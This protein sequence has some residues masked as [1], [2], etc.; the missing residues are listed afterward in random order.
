VLEADGKLRDE[1]MGM[2]AVREDTTAI[3]FGDLE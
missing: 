3:G 1:I 2:L